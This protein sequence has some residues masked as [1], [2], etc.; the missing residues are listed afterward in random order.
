M[1]R[2]TTHLV[3]TWSAGV[4]L[5]ALVA[6][7]ACAFWGADTAAP[8]GDACSTCNACDGG[9]CGAR[10]GVGSELYDYLET[11][12]Q[13]NVMWPYPYICP[14]RVWAHAPFDAMVDNG[15][16]RQNLLGAHHF[17]P[18]T[19]Q[20]TRA[21]QLKVEWILTQT[22]PNRRQVFVERSIDTEVTEA[23][24]AAAQTFASSLHLE[25]GEAVVQETYARSP[26]RPASMVDSEHT[27]FV[28]NRKPAVLPT[29]ST[30]TAASSN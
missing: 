13:A 9:N 26:S 21:G 15:W 29:G 14:D 20:L 30:S 8:C 2:K 4:V 28:E 17:N 7:P 24:M 27:S 1:Q 12:R 11:G 23:R 16:R 10:Q 3:W 6:S 22:P 19:G 25:G 18:E 5:G